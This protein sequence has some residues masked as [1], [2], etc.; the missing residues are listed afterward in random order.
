M[1]DPDKSWSAEAYGTQKVNQFMRGIYSSDVFIEKL[2]GLE[3][4]NCLY[5]FIKSYAFEAH[6]S[7]NKGI[8]AFAMY[9]KLHFLHEVAHTLKWQSHK[10][11]ICINPATFSCSIDEDFIGRT[12]SITRCV[13]PRIMAKRTLQRYLCLIQCTWTHVWFASLEGEKLCAI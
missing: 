2:E 10:C 7:Y 1:Y 9:P 8:S 4:S 13:A 12:A 3:L 6:A 11:G 5:S